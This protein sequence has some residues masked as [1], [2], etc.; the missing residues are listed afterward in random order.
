MRFL[1]DT[2]PSRPVEASDKNFRGFGVTP[3]RGGA[4][5]HS[6]LVQVALKVNS[7]LVDEIAIIALNLDGLACLPEKMD[8]LQI[9]VNK[10]F[11][12]G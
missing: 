8:W 2:T 5:G 10:K 4:P 11:P 9:S 12:F 3:V 7:G 6:Y 1:P